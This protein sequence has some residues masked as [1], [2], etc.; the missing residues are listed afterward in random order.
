MNWT[1][2][3]IYFFVPAVVAAY[4]F[5]KK[6]FS[7]FENDG[8]PHIKATSWILGNLGDVGRKY[9]FTELL[10]FAY[11]ECKGKDVIGGFYSMFSPTI[12]IT[13]LDLVK[14]I[15]IKDFPMFADRGFYVNEENEP[16]TGHLLAL[17]GDR[18]KFLRNK[19]SPAF[20][21]GKIKLMYHTIADKGENLLKAVEKSLQSGS[22]NIKDVATR[23]TVDIISSTAFGFEANTLKGE[24]ENIMKTL[25]R[26]LGEEGVSPIKFFFL[27]TFSKFSKFMNLRFFP[28]DVQTFFDNA[29]GDSIKYRDANNVTRNDFLDMLIQLKNKDSIDGDVTSTASR[30]LTLNECIAQSFIFFLGGA[31]TSSYTIS[32]LLCELGM[33]SEIQEKIREEVNEK[34]ANAN[35][36]LTYD[37]IQEMT[38]LSQAVN[39]KN[40]DFT[41]F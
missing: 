40:F 14:Q 5:L 6:K 3:F 34:I 12:I 13:D 30:R 32:F 38:H 22:V 26:T 29:V 35:G 16:I 23:F 17:S 4:M 25:R 11:E 18:W 7:Y 37:C 9:H 24:S 33:H 10:R 15:M 36:E 8:I 41:T 2:L 20:T 27:S 28:K 39:G 19:L 21:T 1:E 31:D